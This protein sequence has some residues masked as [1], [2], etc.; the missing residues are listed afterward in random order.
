MLFR[1]LLYFM[2]HVNRQC[3]QFA[4]KSC[5]RLPLR[6]PFPPG[7]RLSPT[8]LSP[9]K[10]PIKTNLASREIKPTL[11]EEWHQLQVSHCAFCISHIHDSPTLSVP[12]IL[13]AIHSNSQLCC[14]CFLL[15][16]PSPA[17][18]C[19]WMRSCKKGPSTIRLLCTLDI[20]MDGCM[21]PTRKFNILA[22]SVV[23]KRSSCSSD[24]HLFQRELSVKSV[25]S[26]PGRHHTAEPLQSHATLPPR[27]QG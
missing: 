15:P 27:L 6:C 8:S 2:V 22:F 10:L 18:H 24:F 12:L 21:I 11:A 19:R 4:D 20:Y 26:E 25:M 3:P 13:S 9:P 17:P 7:L 5:T 14:G 23:T 1:G 16:W